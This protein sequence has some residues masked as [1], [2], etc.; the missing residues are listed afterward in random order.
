M[1]VAAGLTMSACGSKDKGDVKS[2]ENETEESVESTDNV[3]TA[4]ATTANAAGDPTGIVAIRKVWKDKNIDVDAGDIT[5]GIKEYALA[6]CKEYPKCETNKALMDYLLSPAADTKDVYDI[7]ADPKNGE[8]NYHIESSPRK[9]HIR[10]IAE[11]QTAP[12]TDVCYWNRSNGH[13]LFAAYMECTHE[14]DEYDERQVVFYDIDPAT[15]I[16]TPDIALAE[17]F[18]ERVKEYDAFSVVLPRDGK[19]IDVTG[20]IVDK[21]NDSAD[22]KDLLMKWNGLS[23]DWK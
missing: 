21:E 7:P 1:F 23:F 14:S 11:V 20:Y 15:G 4:N 2:A 8:F 9:G 10:C 16:M 3:K 19:D 17:M 6:F 5:P 12:L 18:E 13:K 22:T